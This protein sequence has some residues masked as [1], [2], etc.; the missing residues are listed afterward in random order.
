MKRLS[1]VLLLSVVFS[2]MSTLGQASKQD[3]ADAGSAEQA[4]IA[5]EDK[6]LDALYHGDVAALDGSE[7]VDFVLITPTGM[8]T[9]QDHLALMRQRLSD[10]PPNSTTYSLSQQKVSVYGPIAVVTDTLSITNAGDYPIT[11]PGRYWQTEIWHN[12]AG[13]W[14]LVH[15]HMSLAARQRM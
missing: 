7:S 10:G 14:K 1:L 15:L 11:S 3:R 8:I 12:E 2:C 6:W 5:A 9:R 13:Q 4:V